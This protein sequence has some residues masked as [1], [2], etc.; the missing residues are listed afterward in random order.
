MRLPATHFPFSRPGA[1]P[2][3]VALLAAA[4]PVQ[5]L[6]AQASAAPVLSFDQ[7]QRQLA[8]D[9][10]AISVEIVGNLAITTWDLTFRNPENR[11]LEGE[12]VFP[13]GEGQTISRFALPV[14]GQ[15]REG[16]VV[17]KA[18]GRQAFEEVVR[19]PTRIDP[20]V[21][22]KTEGNAF[23]T[24][25]YPIP[26][27]GTYRVVLAYEQELRPDGRMQVRYG[28]PLAFKA[29]VR[30]FSLRMEVLEQ[31]LRPDL[32]SAFRGLDFQAQGRAW[33]A[34]HSATDVRLDRSL[35][36]HL[37]R[38]AGGL[39]LVTHAQA[40]RRAFCAQLEI[41]ASRAPKE[42]PRRLLVVWDASASAVRRDL[43]RERKL[44]ADYL[45]RLETAS[46]EVAVVRNETEAPRSFQVVSG[47]AP[48]LLAFLE[49]LP[50]DGGTRLDSIHLGAQTADEVLLFTDGLAN[51]GEGDPE[52]PDAPL[53]AVNSAPLAHHGRL[54]HLAEDRAGE[55]LNLQEMKDREA[56]E[57]LLTRPL[58]FLGFDGAPGDVH[59]A[60]PAKGAVVRGTFSLAGLQSSETSRITLRFGYGQRTVLTRELVLDPARST[61][62]PGATRLWAQKKLAAL[63]VDPEKHR[64]EI[65]RLGR[66]HNLVTEETSLIVLEALEDYL[67]FRIEP[68]QELRAAYDQALRAEAQTKAQA[69][70][71]QVD[72]LL[73][74]FQELRDWWKQEFKPVE[75][76]A[77][78]PAPAP[79]PQPAAATLPA[80]VPQPATAPTPGP[81]AAGT[82]SLEGRITDAA[83]KP[84]AGVQV[85]LDAQGAE[86][87]RFGR[88]TLV[89][90]ADGSFRFRL[91]PSGPIRVTAQRNGF[92]TTRINVTTR[93]GVT[94]ALPIRMA[95][96][97]SA[98]VE[99]VASAISEDRT[100]RLPTGR[101][102]EA[103]ANLAPGVT[104]QGNLYM[105]DSLNATDPIAAAGSPGG[106]ISLSAW[107]QDMPYLKALQEA[108]AS[109]RY[110]AY[111]NLRKA[112]GGSPGFF[113]DACDVFEQD[114]D[115]PTA[116]R[117]L[118][119]LAELNL[120][121]AALL[122]ILGHRLL[123]L[124]Q[125]DLAVQV[126]R[127]V[128]RLRE[129][130][131]Q[132]L[133]DLALALEAAGRT[134]EAAEALYAV[135]TA[136]EGGRF[137]DVDLIALN[138]L[139]ALIARKAVDVSR[140]DPRLLA[141]L[142]VDIRVV[143]VWD[144]H[145]S[146]MDLHVIDTRG[147]ACNYSHNRTALGGRISHDNTEGYGP[148]EFLLHKALP[149]TYRIQA[150]YYG[151]RQQTLSIGPT[152]L[153]VTLFMDYGTPRQTRK[154]ITLRLDGRGRMLDVGSFEILGPPVR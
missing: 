125:A 103:V 123:Q 17:E 89:T 120:D 41:P 139:N 35:E 131:P 10:L 82:A 78:K 140:F 59:E 134:Q 110:T 54:R 19:R 99:V 109:R 91:L 86:A 135:A 1:G 2:C 69:R 11:I 74:R 136:H 124:D 98:V 133:R 13:L 96:S 38:P 52:F 84:L 43:A 6:R 83:G 31:T 126:F 27:L 105:V 25:I 111:L 108:G 49:A 151:T 147:E 142:P 20:G 75:V 79:V 70:S 145:D 72:Q 141:A 23:R 22:E 76:P 97:A 34:E 12:L 150:N 146:D 30:E 94:Q 56:L 106:T 118:S 143:M 127:R 33:T 107:N 92:Q 112:Y 119:N 88:R 36:I 128:L 63:Q 121:D 95:T 104:G 61:I 80:P 116:L 137:P 68:P 46:V 39:S 153:T 37:P 130:E 149:G 65:L 58:A 102:V 47:K 67:R 64:E 93:F 71:A 101:S 29:P 113:L 40:G 42:R 48:D 51:L 15:L 14:N 100:E 148:E 81:L 114:R 87:G 24:R 55:Y 138:E 8:I 73:H 45:R 85:D 132:S 129:E 66:D 4:A 77:P 57:A 9:R 5:P 26:A 115:R 122:R 53:V 50:L 3:L 152:T 60:Y 16:V 144:T 117:I 44:L 7:G 154:D 21:I 28:L 32:R 90:D 62:H 18:K